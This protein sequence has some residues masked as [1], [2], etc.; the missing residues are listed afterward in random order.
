MYKLTNRIKELARAEGAHLVGVAPV[1]RFYQAPKGHHPTDMLRGAKSVVAFALPFPKG[2]LEKAKSARGAIEPV[3]IENEEDRWAME[4]F[5]FSPGGAGFAY[6]TLNWRLQMIGMRIA[7]VL[8]DEGCVSM[9]TPA[10]GWR[11]KDRYGLF[12]HRHAAVLAGL[13]ELGLHNLFISP[14]YG[15][16]VRLCSVITRAELVPDPML[17]ERVCLG[18]ET[19]GLCLKARECFGEIREIDMAGKKM[20]IAQFSGV[21]P[22]PACKNGERAYIRYCYGVCPI[23]AVGGDAMRGEL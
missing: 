4:Q 15:S 7:S 18:E 14:R 23:G 6:P 8:E 3:L 1:E 21:C 11:A 10:S 9:P 12:S 19:C 20:R 13:G 5:F 16:R 22:S 2:I 17:A